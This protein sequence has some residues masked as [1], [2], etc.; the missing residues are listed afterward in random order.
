M[1][2][3]KK[4]WIKLKR[5]KI[6]PEKDIIIRKRRRKRK[7]GEKVSEKEKDALTFVLNQ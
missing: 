5:Q 2:L 3:S 1:K 6:N 4:K 7:V